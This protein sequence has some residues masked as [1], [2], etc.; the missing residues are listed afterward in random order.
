M[1]DAVS[2]MIVAVIRF[3]K[4]NGIEAKAGEM[5]T[6]GAGSYLYLALL[7]VRMVEGKA[8]IDETGSVEG[9]EENNAE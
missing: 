8:E 9:G 3:L 7:N 2:L 1:S 5:F 6:P 4:R